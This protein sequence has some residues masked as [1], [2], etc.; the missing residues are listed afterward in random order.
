MKP[1]IILLLSVGLIGCAHT[2]TQQ[3]AYPSTVPARTSVVT[4]KTSAAKTS[5]FAK[6]TSEAIASTQTI[7]TKI[8]QVA[9]TDE[10]K[11]LASQLQTSLVEAKTQNDWLTKQNE[12]TVLALATAD[13]QLTTLQAQFDQQT[14]QVE[15]MLQQ[16]AE[17]EVKIANLT[18]QLKKY[19][20]EK[21]VI[22]SLLTAFALLWLSRYIM[23][24]PNPIAIVGCYVVGGGIIWG[25]VWKIL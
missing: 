2:T 21:A 12:A 18:T 6:K 17:K 7:A 3:R 25:A 4:A 22:C 9:T 14:K 11:A 10:Q 20:E 1:F 8:E 16:V 24:V 15:L 5:I 19:H 23:L 13:A